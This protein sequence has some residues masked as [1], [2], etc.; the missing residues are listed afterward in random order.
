MRVL[1]F[2]QY[3]NTP[4]GSYGGRMYEF[5]RRW[6]NAGH[7]V[8]VVSSVY[9]KSD[10]RPK[11][12]LSR[13]RIDGIDVRIINLTL[14]NRHGFL[15]RVM[16]FAAY[17]A[18][19]CWYALVLPAD[20]AVSSSGPLTVGLPG[21]VARYLRGRPLVFEVRDLWPEGAIQLGILRNPWLIALA[22][23]FEKMCYRAST[24][25]VALSP[26]M[27]SWIQ[28]RHKG[29]R[30]SVIPNASDNQLF[31][32]GREA[33]RLPRWAAGKRLVIYAG[34]LGIVDDVGQIVEMAPLLEEREDVQIVIIG[35]GRQ[36]PQLE[37]RAAELGLRNLTFLGLLPRT[38]VM[39][40]LA[41][42]AC[43]LFVCR[44]TR[45]ID[46]ASPNKLFDA[47]AAGLPVVQV[48]Q[49]WIKELFEREQ[50]GL[51]VPQDDP[52]S[53][54]R[55]ILRVLDEP[56]LNRLFRENS[57]RLARQVFDR[58]LLAGEMLDLLLTASR[59][60][61]VWPSPAM[62]GGPKE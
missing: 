29:L 12:F 51:T 6:V 10:L 1:Y 15:H 21:L 25:V 37:A 33:V 38:S 58:D 50:C 23:A 44:N 41:H 9:D 42:A 45:F 8:T 16:T 14:S 28:E 55:A 2:Y 22:R 5:A 53:L 17:A 49:G 36:R 43:A 24:R 26:G 3:F 57:K 48:S 4:R 59:R 30:I 11:S 39:G 56:G 52:A 32:S 20:V 62:A 19:A 61:R 35:D 31:E 46:T 60:P 27:A 40:W 7:E 47:F 54:A 18:V 13:H 34:A